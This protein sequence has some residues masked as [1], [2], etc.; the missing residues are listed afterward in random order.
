MSRL[1]WASPD[2][3]AEPLIWLCFLKMRGA[4]YKT[5]IRMEQNRWCS[6]SFT[7]PWSKHALKLQITF[8]LAQ[9]WKTVLD[10]AHFV[11]TILGLWRFKKNAKMHALKGMDPSNTQR[12]YN[13]TTT[14]RRCSDFVTTL[15][16]HCV[17]SGDTVLGKSTLVK[18]L[19]LL[20]EK[21]FTLKGNNFL[22]LTLS[23]KSRALYRSG[24]VCLKANKKLPKLSSL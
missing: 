22:P 1:T 16:R 2:L 24:V 9:K 19:C 6:V 20:S 11:H 13:I 21:Y 17:F 3:Y 4:W 14:S 7:S 10:H 12:R 18:S 5:Y 23:F 15:M 8:S